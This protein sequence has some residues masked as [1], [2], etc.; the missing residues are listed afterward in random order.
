MSII[1]GYE[2]TSVNILTKFKSEKIVA[3]IFFLGILSYGRQESLSAFYLE[4][5]TFNDL[6]PDAFNNLLHLYNVHY[7][8]VA[9]IF[10][11]HDFISR[12]KWRHITTI[13]DIQLFEVNPAD[14]N[15]GYTDFVRIPGYIDGNLKHIR[16]PVLE[17]LDLYSKE[18]LLYINPRRSSAVRQKSLLNIQVRFIFVL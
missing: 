11:D 7:L 6:N 17:L 5:M 10:I 2:E 3:L 12:G 13:D 14:N 8:A 1:F 4:A 16:E 18:L 9:T 15:F